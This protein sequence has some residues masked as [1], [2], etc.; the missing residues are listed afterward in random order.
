[1]DRLDA[2]EVVASGVVG[3]AWYAMPDAVRS[4]RVRGWLKAALLVPVALIGVAQ[5]RRADGEAGAPSEFTAG[6][7]TLARVRTLTSAEPVLDAG[8]LGLADEGPG[9]ARLAAAVGVGG[10]MLAAGGAGVLAGERALYR[11]GERLAARGVSHPHTRIGI[12][13]GLASAGLAT[14]MGASAGRRP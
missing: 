1:M 10:L 3:F 6:D 12:A 13:A 14:A 8:A 9:P 4:R 7:G 2:A 11:L 5:A